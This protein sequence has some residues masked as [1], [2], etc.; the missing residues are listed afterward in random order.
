MHLSRVY[1]GVAVIRCSSTNGESKRLLLGVE[2]QIVQAGDEIER[3]L[4]PTTALLAHILTT[5][6]RPQLNRTW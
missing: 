4:G 2:V 5:M 1:A 6:L 3:I